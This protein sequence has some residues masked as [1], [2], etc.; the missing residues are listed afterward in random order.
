[1]SKER[2][3]TIG[4]CLEEAG[5]LAIATGTVLIGF[6]CVAISIAASLLYWPYAAALEHIE[7]RRRP[8]QLT[9]AK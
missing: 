2:V 7:R 3:I 1:M 4:D 9:N 5:E 6:C 8:L